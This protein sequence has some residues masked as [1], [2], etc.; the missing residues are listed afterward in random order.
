MAVFYLLAAGVLGILWRMLRP[1]PGR[2]YMMAPI[3]LIVIALPW[4]DE[5][6]IA[7]HFNQA[8]DDAGIHVKRQVVVDGFYDATKNDNTKDEFVVIE[9]RFVNRM[10]ESGFQ[11]KERRTLYNK[12]RHL[13]VQNGKMAQTILDKPTARY[14]YIKTADHS[15]IGFRIIKHESII[16][17]RE[18]NEILGRDTSYS[19]YPSWINIWHAFLNGHG[20]TICNSPLHAP[21]EKR[22]GQIDAYVLK[23]KHKSK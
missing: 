4:A 17:D 14:H 6:W 3:I 13:E 1:V 9:D 5:L 7:Y 20:M 23:P 8:C 10:K 16:L 19:R 15:P 21:V 2:K 22:I 12:V 18:I 11:F